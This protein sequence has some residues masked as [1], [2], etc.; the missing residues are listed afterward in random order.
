MVSTAFLPKYTWSFDD[1]GTTFSNMFLH[2]NCNLLLL[3]CRRRFIWVVVILDTVPILLHLIKVLLTQI[4]MNIV[5]VCRSEI[6]T[7][8]FYILPVLKLIYVR[9]T[10]SSHY[11]DAL[12]FTVWFTQLIH[13][14]CC[15]LWV[16]LW[17]GEEQAELTI[18][19]A[20]IDVCVA[21]WRAPKEKHN[22]KVMIT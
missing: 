17:V 5:A 16:G 6:C 12:V 1:C 2:Y 11:L 14:C 21:S 8:Y 22:S 13:V 9:W 15:C 7:V 18:L 19:A 20:F 10:G 4:N 3:F